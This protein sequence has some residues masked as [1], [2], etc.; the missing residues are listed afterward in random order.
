MCSSQR[1]FPL[2]EERGDADDIYQE[3]KKRDYDPNPSW[4]RDAN[5]EILSVLRGGIAQGGTLRKREERGRKGGI[6]PLKGRDET[7]P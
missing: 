4:E 3:R 6:L 5:M 7:R 1:G 2:W